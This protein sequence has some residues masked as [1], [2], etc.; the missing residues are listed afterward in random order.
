MVDV[1]KKYQLFPS[2]RVLR[3]TLSET[4]SVKTTAWAEIAPMWCL[5]QKNKHQTSMSFTPENR[6]FRTRWPSAPNIRPGRSSHCQIMF[7]PK[8]SLG[9]FSSNSL[10]GVLNFKSLISHPR[11]V[12]MWSEDFDKSFHFYILMASSSHLGMWAPLPRA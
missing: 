11:M 7:I 9:S 5:C 3:A 10:L 12:I 8:D 1:C 6:N 4:S 2:Q